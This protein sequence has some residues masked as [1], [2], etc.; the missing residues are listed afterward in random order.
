M[1]NEAYATLRRI[2][3]EV[4]VYEAC[5]LS[6][7]K[8]AYTLHFVSGNGIHAYVDVSEGDPVALTLIH[9]PSVKINYQPVP[10]GT[11]I[12]LKIP[13]KLAVELIVLDKQLL[14]L[15]RDAKNAHATQGQ[16]AFRGRLIDSETKELS[17]AGAESE[18][19]PA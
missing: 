7:V 4:V 18:C 1:N 17:F 5:F 15:G 14:E 9:K 13:F 8:A 19:T 3:K 6:N 12:D 16:M 10:P 2:D 11:K